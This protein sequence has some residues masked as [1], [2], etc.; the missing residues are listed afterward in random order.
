MNLL[1]DTHIL[2]WHLTDNPKLSREISRTIENPQHKKFISIAS[3]W[4][5]AI[6]RSL[7]KLEILQPIETLTPT[8]ITI[9]PLEISH[10]SYLEKL[11]FH[12]RDPFDRIII[13]QAIVEKLSVITNDDCFDYYE[14]DL[15]K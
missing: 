10:I 5:V 4:E 3:L 6:K 7:G 14:I 11:P 13:A 15:I 12:H 9:L 1:L 2:L 8:E